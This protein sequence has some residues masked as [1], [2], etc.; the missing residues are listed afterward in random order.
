MRPCIRALTLS[1]IYIS[2]ISWSI[3]MK[4]YLNHHWGGEKASVRFDPDRIR[5]LVSMARDSSHRVIMGKTAS[6]RFLECVLIGSFSYLQ[7]TL[8]CMRAW[9]SSKFGRIRPWTTELT[10]LERIKKSNRLIME[11]TMSSHFL[12]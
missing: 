9:M 11:K 8:T 7:V 6:S 2:A 3:G 12:R 1:N 4:F 10:A 5:T